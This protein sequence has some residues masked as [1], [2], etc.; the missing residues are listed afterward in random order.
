MMLPWPTNNK[1]MNT[2]IDE[3]LKLLISNGTDVMLPVFKSLI[4]EAMKIERNQRV[5]ADPYERTKNRQGYANGFKDKTINT[6]MGK[7]TLDI[8]QARGVK[9]LDEDLGQFRNRKLGSFMYIQFD[10]IYE[11]IRYP[12][13]S[14]IA[15]SA[16][17]NRN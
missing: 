4:N 6:G 5:C 2:T 13:S 10:A 15:P 12:R 1:E 11:K 9:L 16:S 14:T 17:G 8:P 7:I 3:V